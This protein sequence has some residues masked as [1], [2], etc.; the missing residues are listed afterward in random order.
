MTSKDLNGKKIKFY[1]ALTL[2]REPMWAEKG[3]I[4]YVSNFDENGQA[5]EVL[6]QKSMGRPVTVQVSDII[7]IA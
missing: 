1:G 3:T 6:V 2:Y 7:E 5:T 4:S